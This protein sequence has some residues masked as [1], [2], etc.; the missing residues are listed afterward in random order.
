MA[1]EVALLDDA[2]AH[3]DGTALYE[4]GDAVDGPSLALAFDGQGVDGG[5]AGDCEVDA[6]D[7]RA[8]VLGRDVHAA[9][10]GG[11]ER[12]VEGDADGVSFRQLCAPV[13]AAGFQEVERSA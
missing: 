3:G 8:D 7:L 13:G 4:L 1:V 6:V 10:P 12:F 5:S 11:V 2:V 9:G